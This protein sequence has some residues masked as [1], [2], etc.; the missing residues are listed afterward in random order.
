MDKCVVLRLLSF[1][2]LVIKMFICVCM[3]LCVSPGVEATICVSC[4]TCVPV[5]VYVCADIFL[6]GTTI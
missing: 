1:D 2:N 5:C 6:T 3:C 4:V